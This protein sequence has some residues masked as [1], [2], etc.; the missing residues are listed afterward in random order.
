MKKHDLR[1]LEDLKPCP[2]NPRVITKEA[3]N[4]LKYS[5]D[6]FGDLSGITW[7][8]RFGELVCGHQRVGVLRELGAKFITDEVHG[9]WIEFGDERFDIRVVD[10]PR[11][12]HDAAMMAA[13]NQ[14]I[15]GDWTADVASLL[16]DVNKANGDLFAGLLFDEL[17]AKQL[18]AV[19]EDNEPIDDNEPMFTM[20]CPKCGHKW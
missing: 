16:D 20:H 3:K 2:R 9:Q 10:W 19:P 14:E 5:V 18:I 8:K 1:S 7:N 6:E 17:S 13:N 15:A 4:G 11:T 12:R